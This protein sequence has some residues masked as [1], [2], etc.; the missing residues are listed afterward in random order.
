MI[1]VL[2]DRHAKAFYQLTCEAFRL[3]PSA[4]V[5]EINE[6]TDYTEQDIAQLLHPDYHHHQI[7]FGAFEDEMLIGF[8][9]LNFFPYTSK[10]HKATIQGL[11][12]KPDY[13]GKTVGRQLMKYLIQYAKQ[14]N[15]EQLILGVASNNIAAKVFCGHLGFEFLGLES[16]ARKY[17]NTYIDEHWLIH[18]M[19]NDPI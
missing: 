7:F 10:S 1:K 5:H 12:V 18:Y 4:F 14:H 16:H 11:F 2:N 8:V 6:R 13:R 17:E 9:Q 3:H 15:I 19:D